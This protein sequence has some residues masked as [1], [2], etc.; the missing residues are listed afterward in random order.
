M[1]PGAPSKSLVIAGLLLALCLGFALFTPV[2]WAARVWR[3]PDSPLAFQPLVPLA[4]LIL[5]YQKWPIARAAY[6][7]TA[8]VFSAQSPKLRGGGWL[9]A[10][11]AVLLAVSYLTQTTGWG[12]LGGVAACAG[13]VHFLW[14]RIVRNVLL[15][16]L[17]FLLWAIPPPDSLVARAT[18]NL[19]IACTAMAGH[20]LN[21]LHIPCLTLGNQLLLTQSNYRLDIVGA[22]SGISILFPLLALTVWLLLR[23]AQTH[24]SLVLKG[25]LIGFAGVVAILLNVARI[26]LMGVLASRAP[27]L[28]TRLHDASGWLFTVAGFGM[29]YFVADRYGFLSSSV[30]ASEFDDD[31]DAAEETVLPAPPQMDLVPNALAIEHNRA[32][33]DAARAVPFRAVQLA[34]LFFALGLLGVWQ[35]NRMTQAGTWLLPLP[36]R[37]P[38]AGVVSHDNGFAPPFWESDLSPIDPNS[39]AILGNPQASARTYGSP[40]GETVSVSVLSAGSF[41][42]YHEPAVCVLGSGYAV[43]AERLLPLRAPLSASDDEAEEQMRAIVFHNTRLRSRVLMLYWLQDRSGQTRTDRLMGSYRDAQARLQTGLQTLFTTRQTCIVR[44]VVPITGEDDGA[45]ARRNA[46]EIARAVYAAGVS[47]AH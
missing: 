19:Q 1:K 22:C 39:L 9:I 26:T 38:M 47:D 40:L 12:I 35:Q 34:A 21:A 2:A 42:A 15:G 3:A 23:S 25:A 17:L 11:S 37:I 45:Q 27:D 10:L 14:G 16:P 43:S 7:E 41:D 20:F 5:M 32:A 6:A 18:Q 4:A 28:V 24:L 13:I 31:A 36:A 33:R 46:C 30:K 29:V 8:F 44:V